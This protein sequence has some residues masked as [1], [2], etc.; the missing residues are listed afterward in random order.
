MPEVCGA[1][2]HVKHHPFWTGLGSWQAIPDIDD[3]VSALEECYAMSPG[4][5]EK[6]RLGARRHALR[7]DVNRV[8]KQHWL[9]TLRAI[10]QR[11]AYRD[12][13]IVPARELRRAA[14]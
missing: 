1:G 4:R 13:V 7:Y 5:R 2:W 3:I 9:P 14:A 6:L 12:P 8:W 10:E 11:F